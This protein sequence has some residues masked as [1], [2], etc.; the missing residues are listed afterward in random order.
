VDP[1]DTIVWKRCEEEGSSFRDTGND[2]IR[3]TNSRIQG[4]EVMVNE[5]RLAL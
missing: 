4:I 3:I 1:Q 5:V 2:N